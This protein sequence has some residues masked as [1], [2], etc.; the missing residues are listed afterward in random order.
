VSYT[1]DPVS[2]LFTRGARRLLD[3]AYAAPGSWQSTVLQN[4]SGRHAAWAVARGIDVTGPDD[5]RG[6]RA[7]T[8][9]ARGFTR[10]L[11]HQ[12]KWYSGAAG[13]G[14]RDEAHRR[15]AY[16]A[17][18]ALVVQVR[19]AV[20]GGRVVRVKYARGGEAKEK[21][22]ARVPPGERWAGKGPAHADAAG[23]DWPQ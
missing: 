15:T 14:W 18:G 10:A 2:Q 20:P 17:S 21:A 6:G 19:G 23:R 9:W 22:V 4:P 1:R 11:Y 13:G 12:H 16:R 5:V 8:R 3:R 7:V